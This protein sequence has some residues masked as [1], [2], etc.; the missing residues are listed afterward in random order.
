VYHLASELTSINSSGTED[1]AADFPSKVGDV[2]K[3][4]ADR[5]S[6]AQDTLTVQFSDIVASDYQRLKTMGECAAGHSAGCSDPAAWQF[7]QDD[8]RLAANSLQYGAQSTFYSAL[9]G[10]KYKVYDLPIPPQYDF[11]T[12]DSYIGYD[13]DPFA[14]VCIFKGNPAYSTTVA[15]VEHNSADYITEH[16]VSALGYVDGAGTITNVFHMHWP[17]GS[18]M[19]RMFGPVDPTGNINKGGLGM[20]RETTFALFP[21][22]TTIDYFPLDGHP[23]KTQWSGDGAAHCLNVGASVSGPSPATTTTPPTSSTVPPTTSTVPPSTS[24]T[25]PPPSTTTTTTASTTTTQP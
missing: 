22:H 13:Y 2:G 23:R 18:I 1:A 25:T 9:V 15:Q 3:D 20:D 5:L 6:D 10:A 8:Q 12:P 19:D 21:T 24:T 14:M 16:Y 17:D 7:T 4:L 11:T